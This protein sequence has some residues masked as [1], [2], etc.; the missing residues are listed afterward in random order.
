VVVLTAELA[1]SGGLSNGCL[2]LCS[3]W[4]LFLM[5]FA[6]DFELESRFAS[7]LSGT[8]GVVMA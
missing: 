3:A 8:F 4:L 6:L 5:C 7:L 2:D 1:V